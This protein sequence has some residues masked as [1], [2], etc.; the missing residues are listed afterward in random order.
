MAEWQ[1]TSVQIA[2]NRQPMS[3]FQNLPLVDGG[4]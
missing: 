1:S 2:H 3:Q 4:R